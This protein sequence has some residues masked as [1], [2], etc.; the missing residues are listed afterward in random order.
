MWKRNVMEFRKLKCPFKLGCIWH[1]WIG[2]KI[3]ELRFGESK[4][5]RPWWREVSESPNWSIVWFICYLYITTTFS[6]YVMFLLQRFFC[7]CVSSVSSRYPC[8]GGPTRVLSAER[9]G[10]RH[11]KSVAFTWR[12]YQHASEMNLCIRSVSYSLFNIVRNHYF[13]YDYNSSTVHSLLRYRC[14]DVSTAAPQR[15]APQVKI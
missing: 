5:V 10:R 14:I 4:P 7:V 15:T 1:A 8:R 9:K 13:Q 3:Q 6:S 11:G 12:H 2:Y